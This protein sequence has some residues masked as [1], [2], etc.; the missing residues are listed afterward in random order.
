[1]K[2]ENQNLKQV[3]KIDREGIHI[4]DSSVSAALEKKN[5]SPSMITGLEI[6]PAKWVAGEYATSPLIIQGPDSPALR[7]TLFHKIMEELYSLPQKDRSKQMLKR[8]TF[9]TLQ[10]PNFEGMKEDAETMKWL[11]S[12]IGSY[13]KMGENPEETEVATILVDGKEKEGLEIFVK[14]KLGDTNRNLL[15]AIDRIS[16]DK[17]DGGVIVEDYKTSASVKH[18]KEHTKNNEGFAEQRQQIIYSKLMEENGNEVS[19]A[20]LIYPM[21]REIVD[22]QL[23]NKTL[24]KKVLK[25]IV[26]A[27]SELKTME[28]NNSFEFNASFLCH[29]CPI[30]SI[31][32]SHWN[33][34]MNSEKLRTAYESQP[35]P[36]ELEQV[37]EF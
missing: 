11:S 5:L 27:D 18:W 33:I 21:A 2:N 32:P 17:E 31:C 19:S 28:E 23:E 3:L 4:I 37:I 15:G 24:E 7:G 12:I 36:E 8:I 22:V 16:V 25:S 29:W 34:N 1:M 14:G 6:C 20:R 26:D 10:E 35:T 9:E 13:Y 30:V